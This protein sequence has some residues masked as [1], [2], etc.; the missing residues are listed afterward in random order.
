MAENEKWRAVVEELVTIARLGK[1][2]L[3]YS[4]LGLAREKFPQYESVFQNLQRGHWNDEKG[5]EEAVRKTASEIAIRGAREASGIEKYNKFEKARSGAER[6][7]RE[8]GIKPLPEQIADQRR[9]KSRQKVS[10]A[11]DAVMKESARKRAGKTPLGRIQNALRNRRR[12]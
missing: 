12:K 6:R 2:K 1:P 11:I 4:A 8:T 5:I 3:I 7:L 9:K 10:K